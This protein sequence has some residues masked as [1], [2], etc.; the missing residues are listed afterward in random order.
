MQCANAM[1]EWHS[2]N[3]VECAHQKS[4]HIGYSPQAAAAA[5]QPP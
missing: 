1:M 5:K 4:K 2:P 3:K